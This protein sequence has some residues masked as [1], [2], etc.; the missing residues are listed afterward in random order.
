MQTTGGKCKLRPDI[1]NELP[2]PEGTAIATQRSQSDEC[3]D[4]YAQF[5]KLLSRDT[6]L[7]G[8]LDGEG[9][10][11]FDGVLGKTR[12]AALRDEIDMLYATGNYL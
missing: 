5:V 8:K 12:C 6:S 10:A 2:V 7:T 3:T 4:V 9:M 11:I 1:T